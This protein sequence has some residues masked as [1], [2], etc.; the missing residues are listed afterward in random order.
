MIPVNQFILGGSDPLLYPSE[1]MTNSIDEQIAFLQSQ[2]QA[3]NEAYRRNAIPNANNG[4][5]QNQQV[6]Q[7]PT[8]QGIWDAIDAEIAPLTQEQQNML[9]SNQD[10][11]NNYNALQ[12][13]VQAEVLN[14]VRGKIE[15][16]EDGKHLLE[17][18]LKLVKLLKS[19]IVE[20]TNKEMELFKAFKE[21][22]KTN[23]NLTYEEFLKK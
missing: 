17:E 2:K 5:T 18:Q 3:I 19:K 1:K 4:V 8:T 20:V 11:V 21:A 15:A 16:S 9:L 12:S 14:L 7:Q 10:Y 6:T 22:S 23:P 13:M